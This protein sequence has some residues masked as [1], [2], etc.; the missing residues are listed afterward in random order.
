ML[1]LGKSFSWGGLLMGRLQVYD[2]SFTTNLDLLAPK[3]KVTVIFSSFLFVAWLILVVRWNRCR[4]NTISPPE[5]SPTSSTSSRCWAGTAST[6]SRSW[7][8]RWCR[9]W[10]TCSLTT[11]RSSSRT[12]GTRTSE[13]IWP[14][15]S[16]GCKKII[17]AVTS[18]DGG[19][20]RQTFLGGRCLDGYGSLLTH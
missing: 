2:N 4:G 9:R 19:R 18:G 5:T 16:V 13:L 10:T 14:L 17:L 11:S 1:L 20:T 15:A 12:C 3:S 7:S 6:S 8:R